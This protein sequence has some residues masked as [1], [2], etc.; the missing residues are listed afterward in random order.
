MSALSVQDW[1]AVLKEIAD[2][3]RHR[4]TGSEYKELVGLIDAQPKDVE[5]LVQTRK[6]VA[7]LAQHQGADAPAPFRDIGHNRAFQ[8]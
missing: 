5:S 1:Q 4:L 3:K 8:V 7:Q 6:L 2:Q